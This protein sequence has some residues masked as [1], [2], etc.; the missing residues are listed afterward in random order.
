MVI[1]P[2]YTAQ[3]SWHPLWYSKAYAIQ[4]KPSPCHQNPM[5]CL[6]TDRSQTGGMLLHDYSLH[7]PIFQETYHNIFIGSCP[8]P[9]TPSPLPCCTSALIPN[10]SCHATLSRGPQMLTGMSVMIPLRNK[11]IPH[12]AHVSGP[13]SSYTSFLAN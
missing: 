5:T 2:L 9:Q 7:L 11:S 1:E 3:G 4:G 12:L 10:P 6:W 8:V 13:H